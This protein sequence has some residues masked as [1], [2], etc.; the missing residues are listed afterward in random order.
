MV[1]LTGNAD[2]AVGLTAMGMG[3][4]DYLVKGVGDDDAVPRAVRYSVERSRT[5]AALE[6]VHARFQQAFEDG[7]LG[8]VLVTR[9]HHETRVIEANAHME[10]I[11]GQPAG[12]LVGRRFEEF[13]HWQD[14]TVQGD[15]VATVFDGRRLRHRGEWRLLRQDGSVVWCRVSGSA[16]HD[17]SGRPLYGIFLLDDVTDHKLQREALHEAHVA[18]DAAVLGIVLIDRSGRC[19][20]ANRFYARATGYPQDE[21]LGLPWTV[22]VHRDDRERVAAAMA[23]AAEGGPVAVEVRGLRKDGSSFD[24]EIVVAPN[25]SS[26]GGLAGLFF[27][28]RD[29]SEQR[30][31]Q[32][33]LEESEVRFRRIIETANDGVWVVG[34]DDVTTFVNPRM[35]E[36]LGHTPHQMVGRPFSDFL[37]A[38]E[39]R[40][41]I[42]ELHHQSGTDGKP[43]VGF[44]RAD[45]S[46]LWAMV[47]TAPMRGADGGTLA[48]VS[49]TTERKLAEEQVARLVLYDGLTGLPNRALLDDRLGHALRSAERR[50]G[51]VGVMF[52]DLDGFKTVNDGFGHSIG[53]E[54]LR[55]GGPPAGRRAQRGHRGALRRG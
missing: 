24:Q 47:S 41:T 33:A 6:E 13:T 20:T 29:V 2:E 19:R 27:F 55:A 34:A 45:G 26:D 8:I 35:A 50:D 43:D 30:S 22:T 46:T 38:G 44:H 42:A 10:E 18:L 52:L 21:L 49:D 14:R 51:L 9:D 40:R 37:G 17:A 31:A 54:L 28:M 36:L 53:D 4:Q 39:Q 32:R 3:A 7:P 23:E 5:E 12:Q 1:V 11:L 48:M 16:I 15:A 25:R